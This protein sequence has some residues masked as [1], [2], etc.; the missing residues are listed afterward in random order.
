MTM[1][2]TF[3]CGSVERRGR[4]ARAA[5]RVAAFGVALALHGWILPAPQAAAQDAQFMVA[6]GTP[7][8]PYEEPP[9][10]KNKTPE[11]KMNMRFPQPVK[12]GD[13]IGLPVLDDYDLTIGYVRR[14]V[15]TPQGKI[16][17]IVTQGGWFGPWFGWGTRLVPVPIEV[18]AILGRQV[19]S[20][21]MPRTEFATAKT[22]S[23]G[24]GSAIA[25][26][27]MIRVAVAR[28]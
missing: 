23:E 11:E 19:A 20:L 15:R 25:P 18:V 10:M 7:Q 21:D 13:L 26:E 3:S 5:T 22:W 1:H 8:G 9:V 14:V 16:Q 28:R 17:L 6:Q 4:S 27:E 2:N 12:V 24:E